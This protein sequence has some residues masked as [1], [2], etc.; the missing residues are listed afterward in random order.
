M[1]KLVKQRLALMHDAWLTKTG[2]KRPG[3][4]A[5]LPL[6]EAQAKAAELERQIAALLKKPS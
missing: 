4:K 5:G 1:L 3:V 6:E 2:H